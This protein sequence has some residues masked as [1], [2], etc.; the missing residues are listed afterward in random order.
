MKLWNTM[1][2]ALFAGAFGMAG[3]ASAAAPEPG[4]GVLTRVLP[5]GKVLEC[6]LKHTNVHAEISG[7]MAQV[8]VRQ[9]FVNES[10]TAIE[11]TYLFPLPHLA[12]VIGYELHINDR[13]VKGK[14]ARREDAQKAFD[15][16]RAKGQTAGLLNQQRPN[17]F[18]QN[19]TNIPPGGKVSVEVRFV[20]LLQLEN[21]SYEFAFPMVVGP[22]YFPNSMANQAT[23]VNPPIA[24]KGTRAGHDISIHVKLSAGTALGSVSSESH[25]ISEKKIDAFHREITLTQS[26]EIPNKDF[27]LRYRL[28]ALRITPSLLTHRQGDAG[29][30]SFVIDPPA[31]RPSE[32]E[33]TPK[34]LVFVIDTSGSM[35]GFPLDKAK[36][37]MLQ[38]IDGLHSRDT[39]NLITFSGDTHLLW[40]KPMPATQEN[41]AAAKQFLQFRQSGGGTEM[42]K[43]IR[44]SLA[45]T[46]S[47]EHMR[48]VCFMT[49]GYVGNES[50]IINEIRRY[51]NARVF[52]FGI[53]SSV[54]RH[55]LDKMAEAG[56]GEVEYVTLNSDGSAAAKRFHQRVRTPLLT[57]VE[58]LWNGLPV[59][60]V[61]PARVP[62]LFSAKPVIVSGRYTAAANGRITIRGKQAGRPYSRDIDVVLPAAQAANPMV[63]SIWARRQVDHLSME[64]QRNRE[65]I[66]TLGLKYGLMTAFTSYYAV[67]ERVVNEGGKVRRIEVPV[68]MP[69]GVSHEML[70][71]SGPGA[72][73]AMIVPAPHISRTR[74]YQSTA[75]VAV[76][77]REV[78][79]E[80]RVTV[81]VQVR[82]KLLLKASTPALLKKLKD[83]GFIA[84]PA[85]AGARFLTGEIAASKLDALRAL[86]E[87]LRLEEL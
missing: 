67:E 40:N 18:Q 6:P 2:A 36:E 43:A 34:E 62:D 78:K 60:D 75:D 54:N 5:D 14:I 25:A 38:A 84:D 33:I 10:S 27:I 87:I 37:A 46:E 8:V 61:V 82:V 28:E 74:I 71:S 1:T 48:I 53:G 52:S 58:V 30:F 63:P 77:E 81:A 11:A 42:M 69:D 13:V 59:T 9:E 31:S 22:R 83:L 57:D 68:D 66:T 51:P 45:G 79:Q 76:S 32:N 12:A 21:G 23:T 44:A 50:E 20:D 19:V 85:A 39:F 15:E 24:A 49:D 56:R 64:E 41:I 55:L 70:A 4:G 86:P 80:K 65:A 73:F 35:H 72:R 29:Y 26:K 17:V 47:Q 7:P 3:D 16:A